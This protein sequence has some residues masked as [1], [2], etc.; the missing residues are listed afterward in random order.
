VR[1]H[2]SPVSNRPK[3]WILGIV[4]AVVAVAVVAF[5]AWRWWSVPHRHFPVERVSLVSGVPQFSSGGLIGEECVAVAHAVRQRTWR[6]VARVIVDDRKERGGAA[7]A[8]VGSKHGVVY[9]LIP[10]GIDGRKIVAET[11]WAGDPRKHVLQTQP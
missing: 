11:T 3:S 4:A 8:F 6:S 5:A 7:Y 1:C 9:T 2:S 10:W